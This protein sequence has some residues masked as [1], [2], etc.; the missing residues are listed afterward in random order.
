MKTTKDFRVYFLTIHRKNYKIVARS[1]KEAINVC[2]FKYCY[3]QCLEHVGF[4]SV[5][6][7]KELR[8]MIKHFNLSSITMC[9]EGEIVKHGQLS[10]DK[11][12]AKSQW[13]QLDDFQKELRLSDAKQHELEMEDVA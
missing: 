12:F 2:R 7:K 3:M 8:S 4:Y 13:K 10:E 11:R 9:V 1:K 6:D 5:V